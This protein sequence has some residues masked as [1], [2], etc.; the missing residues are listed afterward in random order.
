MGNE[1][2]VES[3]NE[4]FKIL[5]YKMKYRLYGQD[6]LNTY[7]IRKLVALGEIRKK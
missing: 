7:E 5:K 6:G 3:Q 1:K 4:K 2:Y